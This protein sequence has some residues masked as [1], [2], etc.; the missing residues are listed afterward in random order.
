M[1]AQTELNFARPWQYK[2]GWAPR[3]ECCL[4]G[5]AATAFTKVHLPE[6]ADLTTGIECTRWSHPSEQ[7]SPSQAQ[8]GRVLACE[9]GDPSPLGR[10]A[11]IDAPNKALQ[12]EVRNFAA[13]PLM[14]FEQ[15]WM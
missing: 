14:Q 3:L 12:P 6:E 9:L 15:S 4:A 10:L 2:P 7:L 8:L 5:S 1:V 11:A 13:T